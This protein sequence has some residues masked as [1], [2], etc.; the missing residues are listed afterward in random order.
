VTPPQAQATAAVVAVAA[1]V[2]ALLLCMPGPASIAANG[3][4]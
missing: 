4:R 2:V 1:V 3:W